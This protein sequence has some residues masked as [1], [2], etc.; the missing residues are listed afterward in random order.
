MRI[1]NPTGWCWVGC[2]HNTRSVISVDHGDH[3]QIIRFL[4]GSHSAED[5]V[6]KRTASFLTGVLRGA[7]FSFSAESGNVN[8][9]S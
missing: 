7:P 4:T 3:G 2:G 5:S 8:D 1:V 6:R 9:D